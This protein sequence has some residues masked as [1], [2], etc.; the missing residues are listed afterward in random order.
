MLY[1]DKAYRPIVTEGIQDQIQIANMN[2]GYPLQLWGN[3]RAYEATSTEVQA[4]PSFVNQDNAGGLKVWLDVYRD[5][6]PTIEGMQFNDIEI[7]ERGAVMAI[8]GG[9]IGAFRDERTLV[10]NAICKAIGCPWLP[11]DTDVVMPIGMLKD[12]RA[13][14]AAIITELKR[15]LAKYG[16]EGAVVLGGL[17]VRLRSDDLRIDL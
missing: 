3:P 4:I 16:E 9:R 14:R 7:T 5:V 15:R 8:L 12:P 6:V 11:E 17:A 2:L 1:L 13:D 10:M